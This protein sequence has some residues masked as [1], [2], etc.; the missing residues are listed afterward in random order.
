[1]RDLP[2]VMSLIAIIILVTLASIMRAQIMRDIETLS[3]SY[4]FE[5]P[6]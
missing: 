5:V 6:S 1:M 2:V 3:E 4:P